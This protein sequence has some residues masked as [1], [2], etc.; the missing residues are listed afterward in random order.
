MFTTIESILMKTLF[1]GALACAVITL[2]GQA[3]AQVTFFEGAEF[4]GRSFNTGQ[5]IRNLGNYGFNDRSSS[6]IVL[7]NRW[8]VCENANFQG[9]CVVLRPG[10]YPSLAAM[11]LNDRVSSV[12]AVNANARIDSARYA[13]PAVPVYDNRRRRNERLFEADVTS[14]RAVVGPPEQRCWVEREQVSAPQQNSSNMPGAVVGALLGGILGHQVGG[15]RGKDL[16]TVGGAIAGGAIGAQVG[17]DGN[18]QPLAT[19]SVQRCREVPSQARPELYDV[20]YSFRGVEHRLQMT[21]PPG[22][23][24][25]VNRQGEPRA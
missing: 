22:P 24:I 25:T 3:S 16:A 15:G 4:Q 23:T 18:P 5:N 1:R 19:Q 8:E 11:G 21:T 13:P 7:Q 2:A 6:V 9:Q 14:V 10:R 20:S 17:R 12:R